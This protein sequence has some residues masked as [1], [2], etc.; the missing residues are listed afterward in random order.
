MHR[1][2]RQCLSND[3]SISGAGTCQSSF[4]FFRVE[5]VMR[6]FKCLEGC[7]L[8]I[9]HT[10]TRKIKDIRS[11]ACPLARSAVSSFLASSWTL[12]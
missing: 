12:D 3:Y 7:V 6:R 11:C 9:E 2:H 1:P 4:E 10:W 8:K 5:T